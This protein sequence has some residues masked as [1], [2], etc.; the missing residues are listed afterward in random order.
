MAAQGPLI[1][2]V[3]RLHLASKDEIDDRRID[4]R[5][6]QYDQAGSPEQEPQGRFGSRRLLDRD[7]ERY[8]VGQEGNGKRYLKIPLD[9]L[10]PAPWAD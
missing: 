10:E 1:V 8:D 3:A 7:L 5:H 9:A 4:E 2:L 6:R